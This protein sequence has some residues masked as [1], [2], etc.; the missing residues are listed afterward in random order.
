MK[1]AMFASEALPLSKTGGLADVTYALSKELVKGGDEVILISPF[2]PCVKKKNYKFKHVGFMPV[3]LSWREQQAE[4]LSTSIEGI[5]YYL[6]ENSYYFDRDNLYGYHD[7]CERFAFFSL[8]CM[9]LLKYLSFQADIIH[10]HDWQVGMVPTLLKEKYVQDPFYSQMKTVL[11]IHN[12]AFKGFVDRYFLHDFWGLD[13]SLFD[14]GRVRFDNMVSSLKA[15][16]VDADKITTVSPTHRNELL[17]PNSDQRLNGVLELRK[18]DFIGILNGIDYEEWNPSTDPLI[19]KNYSSKAW[20]MGKKVCQ[21][22]L[23]ETFHI[24]KGNGPLFGVVSRLSWQK[25]IDLIYEAMKGFLNEYNDCSLIV[26]GSGEYELERKMQD[27]RD[28]Y[29][30]RVGIYIGYNN[31]LSHKIYAGC[32]FFLMPSLFEPCGIS[33]MISQRYGTL[34]VVRYTG[35]LRD[36]VEGY[37]EIN[38]SK[39]DGIGFNNYDVNGL[40]YAIGKAK[41]LFHLPLTYDKIVGNALKKDNSW[42]RS[43]KQYR[44]LYE[45]LLEK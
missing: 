44:S 19:A 41:E 14:S 42:K 40:S 2:Y 1:I 6:I 38:S 13:D 32:D 27:L 37:D 33:Q 29:P 25:G 8:A 10:V 26:L 21:K 39:P 9:N 15:G 7:D 12:P 24:Q 45:G 20:K 16:I 4:I 35:G 22:D 36:T 31:D 11:T 28:N 3:S 43:C 30:N 17:D 34:P 5:T 18:D 23:L